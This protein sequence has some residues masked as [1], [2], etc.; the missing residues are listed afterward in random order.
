MPFAGPWRVTE[1]PLDRQL[2]CSPKAREG[3]RQVWEALARMAS[4]RDGSEGG[5]R[6]EQHVFRIIL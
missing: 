6:H 5:R 1:W 3:N 4:R 2:P